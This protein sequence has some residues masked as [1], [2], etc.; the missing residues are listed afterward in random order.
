MKLF[1]EPG[2]DVIH[3]ERVIF[4]T[5]YDPYMK[6]KKYLAVFPDDPHAPG[7]IACLPFYF[8]NLYGSYAHGGEEAIFEPYCEISYGYYYKSTRIIHKRDARCE[9][10][11]KTVSEYYEG[12]PFDVVEKLTHQ[13]RRTA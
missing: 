11:L 5:E 6:M 12:T 7:R 4:R 9:A 2:M 3:A 13:Q 1:N 8:G 10:L